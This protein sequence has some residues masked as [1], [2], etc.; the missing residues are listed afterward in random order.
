MPSKR[1]LDICKDIS[2][3]C[4]LQIYAYD[5]GS[6]NNPPLFFYKVSLANY[7]KQLYKVCK[8]TRCQNLIA[9]SQ[10]NQMNTFSGRC[11]HM[12]SSF[13]NLLCRQVSTIGGVAAS[14]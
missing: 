4:D 13:E 6:K 3:D 2:V 10:E 11:L 8:K 5:N 7:Y 9:Q 14:T 12:S 1:V